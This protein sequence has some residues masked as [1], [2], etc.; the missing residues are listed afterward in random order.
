MSISALAGKSRA[1]CPVW[2]EMGQRPLE[3]VPAAFS[4]FQPYLDANALGRMA[5]LVCLFALLFSDGV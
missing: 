1:D 4:L 5:D 3:T 2:G